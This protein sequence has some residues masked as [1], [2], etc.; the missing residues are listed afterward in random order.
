MSKFISRATFVSVAGYAGALAMAQR[1][2]LWDALLTR[3]G[4]TDTNRTTVTATAALTLAQ[5][6]VLPVAATEGNMVLTL[7]ASSADAD[8]AVYEIDRIDATAY[9]V[10]IA[11]A[12]ADTIDGAA[13]VLVR[14]AMTLRL[15]AGSTVWRVHS[16][17]GATPEKAREALGVSDV[18]GMRNLLDNANFA[19]NQRVY[20][21]GAATTVANQVTLDRWRVVTSGQNITFAAYGNG[22]IVTVPAGG[23]EEV[24]FGDRIGVA[25]HVINWVGTATCTVDGVAKAKGESV[26]LVPGTNASVKFFA[27]TLAQAQLEPGKVPTAFE[28]RDPRV[29]LAKSCES[30]YE[31]SYDLA[32]APGSPGGG[33]IIGWG[34]T[35]ASATN[36]VVRG[37]ISFKCR[38]RGTPVITVYSNSSGNAGVV[39]SNGATADVAA[40][41]VATGETGFLMEPGT[42][43]ATTNQFFSC[44]FVAETGY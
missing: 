13:S 20:V 25:Q 7:P 34:H 28:F 11:A 40:N 33:G 29:E 42:G 41:V 39:F 8:E 14:G 21:S 9:T 32:A 5:C 10:T 30:E 23:L 4:L 24:V 12:G 22:R 36:V 38:K 3:L 17:S 31:K 2:L 18:P 19:I 44:Q 37:Q 16:I 6:G 26:T 27:G 15:P 1:G 35:S 43:V